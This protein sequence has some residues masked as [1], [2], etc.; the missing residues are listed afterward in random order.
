MIALINYNRLSV[1]I[2]YQL[3][4]AGASI[5]WTVMRCGIDTPGP[6]CIWCR[7]TAWFRRRKLVFQLPSRN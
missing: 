5:R 2:N 7:M 3:D 6:S 4:D 1:V